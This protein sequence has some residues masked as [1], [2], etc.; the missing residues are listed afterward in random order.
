[1]S[2]KEIIFFR[3]PQ[4]FQFLIKGKIQRKTYLDPKTITL[5]PN[6]LAPKYNPSQ[7]Q[8]YLSE[9]LNLNSFSFFNSKIELEDKV[10][11]CKDYNNNRSITSKY[12]TK[13]KRQNFNE[14]G[15]IKYVFEPSRFY[16]LPF[17]SLYHI[18]YND[19]KS[20]KII[21]QVLSDWSDQN[22]FLE[23]IHWTSGIEVGI[24][25]INLIYTHQVLSS[26][27]KLTESIDKKI[28]ALILYN[29]KF[30]KHH[31]SL[32]SSANN[33]LVAEL[34]GLTVI[35]SYFSSSQINKD[36]KRWIKMLY[37]E[38]M[39]QINDDGVNME[40]STHYHAEVTDHFFN[41]L[42]FIEASSEVIPKAVQKRFKKMFNFL[43]HVDYCG[44]KTIFGDNDNG[45]L[46]F[47]Y[48]SKKFSIYNSLLQTSDLQYNTSFS[49]GTLDLRNVLIFGTNTEINAEKNVDLSIKDAIFK[50]SGYMFLYDNENQA[51]LAIDFG[52]IGDKISAAHGHSD[53]LHFT[54][55]VFGEPILIDAGTYQ[56]HSKYEKERAYFRG[57]KAHNTISINNQ[58][59]AL[60]L[61]RMSWIN[62][63][64]V[65]L[66]DYTNDENSSSVLAKHD[67][68]NALGIVHQRQIVFNKK[69]KLIN[70][71]DD[72]IQTKKPQNPTSLQFYLN[73]NPKLNI[74]HHQDTLT[75][76]IKNK[77]IKIINENFATGKFFSGEKEDMLGWCSNSYDTI[78]KGKVFVVSKNIN[79]T[80]T[81][82]TK[83]V[84]GQ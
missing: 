5:N 68:Y 16:F 76:R 50:T 18:A 59:Q 41:A 78:S 71:K 70:I 64:E 63:P 53:I 28:K 13:Y 6:L 17:L 65:E 34:S 77:E 23:S 15:D 38:I 2:F 20:I 21:E 37:S 73:F 31:L 26:D 67:A 4:Q 52:D 79:S 72:L 82:T 75:I 49:R 39:K 51:K 48:Y 40:L 54:F 56:Y 7:L 10:N 42:K 84:Y 62:T 22:P 27:N 61:S 55:E 66:L 60:A 3:I 32:Y 30:L 8:E 57:V 9:D 12:Y 35:S 43:S 19:E 36:R 25:S 44:N 45:Y 14:V 74:T 80:L 83:I 1:M 29:Y 69:D 11:W 47:P 46:V 24:R 81:L 33:H 58:D